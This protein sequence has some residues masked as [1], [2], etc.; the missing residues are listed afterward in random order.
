V[1][2]KE[3]RMEVLGQGSGSGRVRFLSVGMIKMLASIVFEIY[4]KNSI[5]QIDRRKKSCLGHSKASLSRC[6]SS[7]LSHRQSTLSSLG[8]QYSFSLSLS[9]SVP[10]SLSLSLSLPLSL[11]TERSYLV[12]HERTMVPKAQSFPHLRHFG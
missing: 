7:S 5:C 1:E 12:N 9:L 6:K 2:L 3:V 8:N 11:S 10:L 4:K